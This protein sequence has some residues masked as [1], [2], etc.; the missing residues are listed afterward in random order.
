[1]KKKVHCCS[2]ILGAAAARST[3][4]IGKRWFMGEAVVWDADG[5]SGRRG[6]VRRPRECRADRVCI[7]IRKLCRAFAGSGLLDVDLQ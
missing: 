3:F 7:G 6:G 4:R 2:V 5:R 1:M